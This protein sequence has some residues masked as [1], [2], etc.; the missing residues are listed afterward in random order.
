M[1]MDFKVGKPTRAPL[2]QFKAPGGKTVPTERNCGPNVS[3]KENWAAGLGAG[4]EIGACVA[5]IF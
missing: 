5:P 3:K 2:A 1:Q 4:T